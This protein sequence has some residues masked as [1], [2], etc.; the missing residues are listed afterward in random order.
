MKAAVLQAIHNNRHGE[1]NRGSYGS[2]LTF[3]QALQLGVNRMGNNESVFNKFDKLT[4]EEQ[5]SILSKISKSKIDKVYESTVKKKTKIS[6]GFK[7]PNTS[8]KKLEGAVPKNDRTDKLKALMMKPLLGSDLKA[9][10]D[11]Y[12]AIPNPMMISAFKQSIA[13]TGRDTDL[14]SI[15]KQFMTML[16][17]SDQNKLAES[18][19]LEYSNLDQ[20]KQEILQQVSQIDASEE[21]ADLAKR[22][23][24]LLDTIYTILNKSN[25]LNRIGE[26][27]PTVLRDEY[28]ERMVVQIA[29]EMT[30]APLTFKQRAHF[31]QNLS[32]D[33]VIN[34]K[35]LLTPG[36]YTID[37]LTYDDPVNKAMFNH[38][39]I[40]GVGQQMKGPA[41]HAL[42][43]L[44]RSISI[45][46]KGDITIGNTA[47]E[48]KAAVSKSPS[49]GGG[50]FGETGNVPSRNRMIQVIT[51]NEKLKPLIAQHLIKQ[52]SLN[53]EQFVQ[54]CNL[55]ELEPAERQTFGHEV[56]SEVFGQEATPV[57]Q[58]F[59]TPNADPDTV[60]KA[61]IM[62]NFNWYKNSDMGGEWS[63]LAAISFAANAIGV[64]ETGEDLKKISVY[65]KNP[66][67]ITTDKPQEMLFQFNP[68][69]T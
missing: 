27:L 18:K 45:Q 65:K 47:V 13:A 22:N 53:I 57:I 66:A 68:K 10:F 51:S 31:A 20:A 1:Q 36:S 67:I 50:R 37:Q 35:I 7:H 17:S 64:V 48:I 56:F 8:G 23:A 6:K 52:K 15:V 14:R 40:F 61:Y 39:K 2:P 9:Q 54:L 63:I 69:A 4:L 12:V 34:P 32:D 24:D 41:E 29:Q 30:T 26:V 42:A 60:R 16:H 46:G 19:L 43:I 44:C 55:A 5:L 33:K 58:A 11:A 59:A 38:L 49:G 3:D 62:S 25:V 28:S 21:D